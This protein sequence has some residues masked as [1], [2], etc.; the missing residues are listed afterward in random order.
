[1]RAEC[2]FYPD[3][4]VI[5]LVLSFHDQPKSPYV[6]EPSRKVRVGHFPA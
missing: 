5:R 2:G 4:A 6:F 1:L 3:S